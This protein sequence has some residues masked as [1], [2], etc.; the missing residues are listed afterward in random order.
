MF[1][2]TLEISNYRSLE[3]IILSDMGQFNV[4]MGRNNSGKS[5]VFNALFYLNKILHNEQILEMS[6]VVT[7]GDAKRLLQMRLVFRTRQQDREEFIDLLIA[8]GF[9]E[10]SKESM[11]NSS[12]I[13][14]IEFTFRSPASMPH[15]LH[16]RETKIQT[17]DNKWAV[18]QRMVGDENSVNPEN[19]FINLSTR[20]TRGGL[21]SNALNIDTDST[22][23]NLHLQ[24]Y[25]SQ[26]IGDSAT[27]WPLRRVIR[28]LSDAFFFN[29]FRH[30]QQQLQVQETPLLSQDGTNLAQV[31]HTINS[32]DREKF[33]EIEAFIQNAL[34]NVGTMQAPLIGNNTQISFRSPGGHLI[35]LH[36]MGGGIEQLL[37]VAAVLLTT[38]DEST[39]FLEEPES[40]LHAGAQRYLIERLFEGNRQI[41]LTTHSPTFINLPRRRSLYQ[42]TYEN[43]QSSFT[44]LTN[45]EDLSTVLSDIG[46]RNS[47][48]LLSDA[49]FFVE[50][51]GDRDVVQAWS[52]KL[53]VNLAEH[54]ITILPMGGGEQ[55]ERGARMRSDILTGI[56]QKAPV[57]HIFLLDRDERSDAEIQR[58]QQSLGDHVHFLQKREIENYLLAPRAI[59][60]ALK[61]KYSDNA[62]ILEQVEASNPEQIE[63]ILHS[64]ASGLY[65]LV[66][67]KR[68]R[69]EIGGLVGGFLPRDL[70]AALATHAQE[71]DLLKR[72]RTAIRERVSSHLIGI[73]FRNIVKAQKATLDAIWSDAPRHV[74]L[75]PGEELVAA[76]FRHF[77]GD[78]KKPQD[79]VRIAKMMEAD[80][81]DEE[82]HQLLRRV[83]GLAN[84]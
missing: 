59:L 66:L 68:I 21:N 34:P 46:A 5:S 82:I 74:A 16:L 76:L 8:G 48:M 31:L 51:P 9:P 18:I 27:M 28:Y 30:S 50:G 33:R 10:E 4:L 52:E 65:G 45:T 70:V 63:R 36:D 67:L 40:H 24:N 14:Q 43:G 62:A 39:I 41:F 58:L 73:D 19:R 37:M 38:N 22:S 11:I 47:D 60:A 54:N 3:Q 32:N 55:V 26:F 7:A 77:G 25:S 79:T 83:V 15:Y 12:L 17:E 81:I 44:R 23:V 69:N 1:L 29:P 35:P 80:E 84:R 61:D 72:L 6:R 20:A 56:S 78:Y 2:Q 64:T 53:G 49:V 13:R 42:V 57:P 75:A 71:R